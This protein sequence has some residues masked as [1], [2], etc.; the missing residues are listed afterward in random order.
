MKKIIA[1]LTISA[2]GVAPSY[3]QQAPQAQRT[4]EGTGDVTEINEDRPAQEEKTEIQPSELPE[5]V[6]NSFEQSEYSGMNIV[7]AYEL[8]P[9]QESSYNTSATTPTAYPEDDDAEPDVEAVTNE[10]ETPEEV[11]ETGNVVTAEVPEPEDDGTITEEEKALYERN[12]Y[13]KYSEA[14][15][16]AYAEI[17]EEKNQDDPTRVKYELHVASGQEE[18]TLTYGS[19]GELLETG[20]GSM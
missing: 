16:D 8:Y 2:A 12:Q 9:H 1:I 17:A 14:N 13:G 18:M 3:A 11:E 19:N 10:A 20:Q 4:Q 15:S 7:V 6:I 5:E